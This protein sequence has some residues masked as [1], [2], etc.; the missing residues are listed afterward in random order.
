VLISSATD[1]AV[2]RYTVNGAD[3]TEGDP[4]VTAGV[5]IVVSEG[6]VLKARAWRTGLSPSAVRTGVYQLTGSVAA[7]HQFTVALTAAGNLLSWGANSR[8]Q[9]GDGT[10]LDRSSPGPVVGLPMVVAVAAGGNHML[11]LA[12]DG[13][14]WSWGA[15]SAGQ[16][17]LGNQV[18]R[19][20]P[21]QLPSLANIVAIAAGDEFSLA[22]RADGRI[23]AWGHNGA[24]QLGDLSL[25][26]RFTPVEV[27]A[28]FGLGSAVAISAGPTHVLA[29]GS[30]YRVWGWGAGRVVPTDLGYGTA[31]NVA[32]GPNATLILRADGDTSGTVWSASPAIVTSVPQPMAV[33]GAVS[34]TALAVGAAGRLAIRTDGTLLTWQLVPTGSPLQSAQPVVGVRDAV[35]IAVGAQHFVALRADGTVLSWGTNN[36]G[37]LGDGTTT[38]RPSPHPVPGVVLTNNTA[39]LADPD[40]DGLTTLEESRVGTDPQSFDT[41]GDGIGDG[42]AIALGLSPTSLDMDGDGLT[43]S[44]ERVQGTDP[45]KAD[46]DGDGVPDGTDCLPLDLTQ[47]TCPPGD[48]GD[49]TPPTITLIR[50][51]DA[52][53][54]SSIP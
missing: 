15:N 47:S 49:Q 30:D 8:G 12:A 42:L 24:G 9:L 34:V 7:G 29:L 3:P 50:P 43:N 4:A 17:G 23:M 36:R 32:A 45:F 52:V 26:S 6:L 48:P 2:I 33:P 39:L 19:L 40:A 46:T 1:G 10:T 35:A 20:T 37:Q 51:R 38:N 21:T 13:R 16:L 18:D 31:S 14:V 27:T 25:S 54:V 44:I 5:P 28:S 41:N 22:L 53:L 11:A